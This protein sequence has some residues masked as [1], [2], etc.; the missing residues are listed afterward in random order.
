CA[1]RRDGL[2]SCLQPVI[3]QVCCSA[4]PRRPGCARPGRGGWRLRSIGLAA[5]GAVA[6]GV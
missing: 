6:D 5:G 1:A 2:L 4:P 3:C